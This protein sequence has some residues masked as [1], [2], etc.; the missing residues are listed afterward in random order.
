MNMGFSEQEWARVRDWLMLALARNPVMTEAEIVERL[1]REDWHLL[2]TEHAACIMELS[3][4]DGEKVATVHLIGGEKNRALR[5]IIVGYFAVCSWLRIEGFSRI[6]GHPRKGF[7][8]LLKRLGFQKS[9][10]ELSKEL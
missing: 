3:I 7:E 5:E 1:Q 2:S 8:A 10:Q 6:S 4:I 9:E